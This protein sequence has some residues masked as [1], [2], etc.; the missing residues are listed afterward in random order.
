MSDSKKESQGGKSNEEEK[1]NNP[2]YAYIGG[3]AEQA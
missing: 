3:Q 2:F 1:R